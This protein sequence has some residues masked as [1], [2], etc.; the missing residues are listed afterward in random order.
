MT[1]EP[2]VPRFYGEL[3][4]WWPLISPLEDYEEEASFAATLLSSASIPVAE[5]LEL[6]SGG[7]H[8]ASYLKARFAMTLVDLS[9]EMLDV[10]RRL[11]PDCEH[12]AGDMRSV[13]LGRSFDAVFVH[14]AID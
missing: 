9:E 5:V 14:D 13:R 2:G 8:N 7:G 6:G 4:I 12:L 3:A 11:N 1:D 10:S